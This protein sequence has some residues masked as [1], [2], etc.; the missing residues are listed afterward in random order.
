MEF[1]IFMLIWK[2]LYWLGLFSMYT[3]NAKGIILIK[4][5]QKRLQQA[6]YKFHLEEAGLKMGYANLIEKY[7][8]LEIL[9]EDLNL[10]IKRLEDKG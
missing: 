4:K 10:K 2:F 1:S 7:E 3:I 9:I 8:K 5:E 6:Q